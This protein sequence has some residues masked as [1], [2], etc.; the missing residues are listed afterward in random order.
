[1]ICLSKNGGWSKLLSEGEWELAAPREDCT[2]PV[3]GLAAT[4]KH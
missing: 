3:H 2:L 1:M 4:V